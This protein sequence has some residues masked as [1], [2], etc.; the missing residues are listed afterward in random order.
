MVDPRTNHDLKVDAYYKG[1]KSLLIQASHPSPIVVW[2][3]VVLLGTVTLDIEESC[4]RQ[5]HQTALVFGDHRGATRAAVE[6]A[7]L[8]KIIKLNV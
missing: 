5:D 6:Q 2:W 4:A 3:R 7:H 8:S 1:G